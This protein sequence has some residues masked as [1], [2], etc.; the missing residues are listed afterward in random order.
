MQS[1]PE[2]VLHGLVELHES[3]VGKVPEEEDEGLP[4]QDLLVHEEDHQHDQ[5][6]GVEEDVAD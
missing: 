6:Q 4:P 5:G 3:D 1:G 2:P